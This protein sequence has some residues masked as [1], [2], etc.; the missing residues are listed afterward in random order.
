MR[1][2]LR[3]LLLLAC[4][5][6]TVH[7]ESLQPSDPVAW[8]QK[9]SG[10]ARQLNYAG[11]FV[12]Q[13]GGM[14]ETSRIT[15]RFDDSGEHEKLEA[16]DGPPREIIRNNNEVLC[17]YSHSKTVKVEKRHAQK[18]FPALLPAQSG[19]LAENYTVK[20]G[21]QER[22]AG[23]DCQVI[24][25]EPKD[26]FRYGHKLWADIGSGLLLKASAL[27]DKGQVLHQ[28]AFTQVSIGG[29][30]DRE[31]LKP[32]FPGGK[33]LRHADHP[34]MSPARL[35]ETGWEV[36]QPPAGFKKI[37]ELQRSMP[38]KKMPVAHLVFSDGLAAVSVF[39]EPL[40]GMQAKPMEGVFAQGPVNVYAKPVDSHQVTVL[41]EVPGGTVMQ[42]ANSVVPKAK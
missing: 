23:Y 4:L 27:D 3:T 21:E 29:Q 11:T 14:V 40:A 32:A 41:G 28:F 33:Q 9:I 18:N 38:G 26:G 37:M 34:A 10:A 39:I 15:H 1:V 25:L 24:V 35:S 16:L 6:A 20:L 7:A 8:L 42:V 17:Y 31:R 2:L 12:Y 36:R 19:E 22:V 13:H 5:P 30:I